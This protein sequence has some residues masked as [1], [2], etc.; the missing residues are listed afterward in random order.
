MQQMLLP[1]LYRGTVMEALHNAKVNC[2]ALPAFSAV[3][4]RY[5]YR[6]VS[7]LVIHSTSQNVILFCV[8]I[9]QITSSLLVML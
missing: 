3:P 8:Q 1:I 4:Y 9:K 2:H 7:L 6:I 5:T